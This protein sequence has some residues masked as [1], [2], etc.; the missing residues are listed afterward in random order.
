MRQFVTSDIDYISFGEHC[1]GTKKIIICNGKK[2]HLGEYLYNAL[3]HLQGRYP[4]AASW[5]DAICINQK[6]T[7]ERSNQVAMMGGIYASAEWTLVE[8]RTEDDDSRN[9]SKLLDR[10]GPPILRLIEE[11]VVSMQSTSS[12]STTLASTTS[13]E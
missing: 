3:Y 4:G 7:Q 1:R 6:N 10:V 9:T 2:L 8:L 13:S 11:T 5:V 12:L